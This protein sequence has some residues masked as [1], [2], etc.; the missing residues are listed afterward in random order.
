MGTNSWAFAYE[1]VEVFVGE[2]PFTSSNQ[3]WPSNAV[4]ELRFGTRCC[5]DR[6]ATGVLGPK[7][8]KSTRDPND[9]ETQVRSISAVFKKGRSEDRQT[10]QSGYLR[11]TK[12]CR[13]TRAGRSI[14]QKTWVV[15]LPNRIAPQP[16]EIAGG[17]RLTAFIFHRAASRGKPQLAGPRPVSRPSPASHC[18]ARPIADHG[19]TWSDFRY[20]SAACRQ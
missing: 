18:R 13:K 11:H 8:A 5:L 9:S 2:S 14:F 20:C 1:I 10:A 12:A 17:E 16:L 15:R 3:P 19:S 4:T 6:S 7:T